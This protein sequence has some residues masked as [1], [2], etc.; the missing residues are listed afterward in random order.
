MQDDGFGVVEFDGQRLLLVFAER[1][2]GWYVDEPELIAG[3]GGGGEH[4]ERVVGES[5][6][7]GFS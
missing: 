2:R 3:E 4:V 6:V 5:L 7:P 1:M